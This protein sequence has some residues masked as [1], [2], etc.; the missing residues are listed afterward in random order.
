MGASEEEMRGCRREEREACLALALLPGMDAR[1]LRRLCSLHGSAAV[2]WECL[3]ETP[4]SL[5]GGGRGGERGREWARARRSLDPAEE[6]E[7]L[8]GKGIRLVLKGEEDYPHM[9]ESIYD[10]PVALFLRGEAFPKGRMLA[11]VG[12]RRASAQGR[13]FSERLGREMAEAG[14]GVVSGG[15]YGVDAAAHTGALRAGGFTFAVLGHGLDHVYPPEHGGLFSSIRGNGCLVSEYAPEVPPAAWH[16]PERNRIIA[17]MCHGV[18]VVEGGERSGALITAEFAM[19]EGRDVFAVPGSLANPLSAAPHRLIQ[20]GAK[21]VTCLEDVLEELGW[22]VAKAS[23]MPVKDPI[24]CE[25]LTEDEKKLLQLL[26]S[27]PVSA[28]CLLRRFPGPPFYKALSGLMIKGFIG[29]EPGGRY[30]RLLN[31]SH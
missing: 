8:R 14:I 24:D 5:L 17:G 6:M 29:E 1:T 22:E 9:L 12:S 26:G 20:Q 28:E 11:L 16:F 18:V 4:R 19:E 25:Q 10:P 7:R 3:E 30:V 13:Q 31:N 23:G 21:L 2:A 15:A 27:E